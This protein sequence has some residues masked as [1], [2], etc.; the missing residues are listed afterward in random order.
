MRVMVMIKATKNSEAGAKPTQVA[1]I[2]GRNLKKVVL[3]LGGSDPFIL[4][5]TDD[6]FNH[7]AGF[8]PVHNPV[9][10]ERPLGIARCCRPDLAEDGDGELVERCCDGL[11]IARRRRP[12]WTR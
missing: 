8:E 10:H 9:S 11:L 1:E 7:P 5:G 3:E 2:A 4:L 6:M 12:L